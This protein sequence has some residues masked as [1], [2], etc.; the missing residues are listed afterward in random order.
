MKSLRSAV[1]IALALVAL[2]ARSN[3][4]TY[5][6][7]FT[8]LGSSAL[9][10]ELGKAAV[11]RATTVASGLGSG[12][13]VCSWSTKDQ[14]AT[15][16]DDIY[17]NDVYPEIQNSGNFWA[18]WT[19]DAV[20]T[21]APTGTVDIWTDLQ[22]DSAVGNRCVFRT[23]SSAANTCLLVVPSAIPGSVT[24][25]GG[26]DLI[27]GQT[28]ITTPLWSGIITALNGSQ[29]EVGATDVRPEDSQ[30]QLYRAL[31][32]D[33]TVISSTG[34]GTAEYYGLGL[35]STS[36]EDCPSPTTSPKPISITVEGGSD[37][38]G[39][40]KTPGKVTAA[41]F[42][43]PGGTDPCSGV[44]AYTHFYTIPVGATPVVIA[45]NTTSGSAFDNTS[46]TNI[47]RG[48]LAA[49]LDGDLCRSTD[50][51]PQTA[52]TA[53]TSYST[54]LIREPF[55]GTY[56]TIEYS[57][58]ASRGVQGSQES[59]IAT[60]TTQPSAWTT[61]DT[62]TKGARSRVTSTGNMVYA[63]QN[64]ESTLGYFFWS[65]ANGANFTSTDG[66]PGNG[67]Y[68]TVDG[69]DPLQTTYSNGCVPIAGESTAGCEL[70][71]VTFTNIKDG[72]YP[73]WSIQRLV[74]TCNSGTG[75]QYTEANNMATQAQDEVG[76]SLPDFVPATSLYVLHSHF[77]PPVPTSLQGTLT[78][79]NGN[80]GESG[81]KCT[82]AESGGDVGGVVITQQ[83]D[84]DYCTDFAVTTGIIN[85]RD[86]GGITKATGS[87]TAN[88]NP[89]QRQ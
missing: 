72:N 58:A 57:I 47:T 68:L 69:I 56:T 40:A 66:A 33:T 13:H 8:S 29:F 32:P 80:G 46:I 24:D 64:Y 51:I 65:T 74:T 78:V 21:S 39:S 27:S 12:Y 4:Q 59:G 6:R 18:V 41:L 20:C 70:S 5:T 79:A 17:A 49:F 11:A 50:L 88:G 42:A 14:G 15:T 9:F 86:I 7:E 75:C 30:F 73:I 71:D 60:P 63:I 16:A 2:A 35:A 76:P 52:A 81:N 87:A 82:A 3:A 31:E 44:A 38:G 67:K 48:E 45:V 23:A 36:T 61:C 62:T 54:T 53:S 34:S 37:D 19:Q 77:L 85:A 1:C 84:S 89:G 83:A 43:L 28:D 25:K 10:L 26:A 22:V 55:S